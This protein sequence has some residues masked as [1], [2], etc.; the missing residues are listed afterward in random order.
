[1]VQTRTAHLQRRSAATDFVSPT[2]ARHLLISLAAQVVQVE[3]PV[4]ILTTS[5]ALPKPVLRNAQR[6]IHVPMI[7]V[8]VHMSPLVLRPLRVIAS[9]NAP[10]YRLVRTS[11]QALV[12]FVFEESAWINNPSLSHSKQQ[13]DIA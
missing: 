11:T 9:K 12:G 2:R 4:S 7:T 6:V 13:T 5:L 1:M 3:S 8:V 10:L